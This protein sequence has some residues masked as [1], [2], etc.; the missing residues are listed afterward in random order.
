MKLTYKFNIQKDNQQILDWFKVSKNLYNQANYLVKQNLNST[1]EWVRYSDLDVLMK[2]TM[3]LEGEINYYKLKSQTNQQIL[4]LL[5]KNWSSYFRSIKDW[6]KN[7]SKYNGMPK[8]P[9]Y[10]KQ[11]EYLLIFTNQNSII[12]NGE[13]ILKKG[14]KIRIPE[15]KGKDFTNFNQI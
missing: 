12:R 4:R 8:P 9:K 1:G 13:I 3:N 7:S 2:Q 11:D 10:L 14:L 6:K 5:D 15:Y